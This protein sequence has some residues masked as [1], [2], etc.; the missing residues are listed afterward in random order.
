MQLDADK[1]YAMQTTESGALA[2]TAILGHDASTDSVAIAG[3]DIGLFKA[4]RKLHTSKARV[5]SAMWLS[6]AEYDE[7]SK[8]T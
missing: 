8:L 7:L 3:L 1:S 2:T 5:C 4:L 6:Y